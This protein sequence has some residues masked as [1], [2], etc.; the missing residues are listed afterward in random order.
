MESNINELSATQAVRLLGVEN[1]EDE[2]GND[3][4][5]NKGEDVKPFI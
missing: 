5:E 4:V 3:V 1:V 2:K